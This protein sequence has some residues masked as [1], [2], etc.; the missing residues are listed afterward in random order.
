MKTINAKIYVTGLD[1]YVMLSKSIPIIGLLFALISFLI[2]LKINPKENIIICEGGSSIYLCYFLKLKNP[3]IKF[4]YLAEDLFF[5]NKI[6][7]KIIDWGQ[8]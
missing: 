5:Y 8:N 6:E 7:D 4:I 1:K 2:R 3:K